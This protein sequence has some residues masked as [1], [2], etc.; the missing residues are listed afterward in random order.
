M[1]R[2]FRHGLKQG[3]QGAAKR[4]L[5]HDLVH[6]ARQF[7]AYAPSERPTY[8]K[9]RI[10]H[11]LGLKNPKIVRVAKTARKVLFVCFGNIMR[12]PMCEYLMNREL[13]QL[14]NPQFAITSA[15]LNAVPGNPAHSWA[16]AAAR[17]FGI[18]L[19]HH[20]ARLLTREMIDQ[21]DAIFAMDYQNQVQLLSRWP[22]AENKL[23][24]LAAYSSQ[25]YRPV[26]IVDP[27]YLGQPQTRTCF[28]ILN[29]CIQNLAGSLVD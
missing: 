11:G 22:S 7:R 23:F 24:M 6:E 21:A 9:L 28:D 19:E 2:S 1:K 15:G 25:E 29:T 12:S 5:P 16:I 27:Y 13:A 14:G 20:R 26:E 10:A 17:E 18:S 3:I 8:L 4:L